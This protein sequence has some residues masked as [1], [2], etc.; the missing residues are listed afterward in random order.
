MRPPLGKEGRGPAGFAL[1][2]GPGAWRR[3]SAKGSKQKFGAQQDWRQTQS[4]A[5]TLT[6]QT[7]PWSERS[8][9]RC[10]P[11]NRPF[12]A[13]AFWLLR[14]RS[15]QRTNLPFE[16]KSKCLVRSRLLPFRL[17]R[18]SARS[19]RSQAWRAPVA[20][21]SDLRVESVGW[22]TADP[23]FTAQR[24]AIKAGPRQHHVRLLPPL[25]GPR[26]TPRR[27]QFPIGIPEPSAHRPT[28]SC[29]G[30]SRT[31]ASTAPCSTTAHGVR[32]TCTEGDT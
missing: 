23:T 11:R 10:T 8:M 27:N 18:K 7:G 12:A 1:D 5:A 24:S 21:Q 15:A 3:R 28:I 6:A 25:C 29:L 14:P 4:I 30:A 17:S 16:Q 31:P 19:T 13:S 2:S 32:E 9:L 22:Q 20:A 26:R